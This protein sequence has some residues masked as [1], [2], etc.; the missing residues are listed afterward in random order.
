M[1]EGKKVK[2]KKKGKIIRMSC[3]SRKC[4]GKTTEH[5]REPNK[6]TKHYQPIQGRGGAIDYRFMR[7]LECGY[8]H[9][10]DFS[11]D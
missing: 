2:T 1:L 10:W 9:E 3:E 5:T 7:C 6:E 4:K 11:T 8:G